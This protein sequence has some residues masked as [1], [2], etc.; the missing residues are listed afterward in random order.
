[1]AIWGN[2]DVKTGKRYCKKALSYLYEGH[3]NKMTWL[4]MLLLEDKVEEAKKWIKDE[5]TKYEIDYAR[6]LMKDYKKGIFKATK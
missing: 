5:V 1:M 3:P 6:S 2:R 4:M